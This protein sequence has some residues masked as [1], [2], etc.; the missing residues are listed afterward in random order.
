[1]QDATI[2]MMQQLDF[3]V[4][5]LLL[6]ANTLMFWAIYKQAKYLGTQTKVLQTQTETITKNIQFS[7][8]LRQIE[9]L[10]IINSALIDKE[11]LSKTF[12]KMGFASILE[13][14]SLENKS[15][16]NDSLTMSDFGFSWLV[17][18]RYE[19]AFVANE[20]NLLPDSEWKVWETRIKKD[21][22]HPTIR[23]VWEK[24]MSGFDYNPKFKQYINEF[25]VTNNK[26][27]THLK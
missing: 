5:T 6:V 19:C 14:E 13:K 22:Y 10:N 20:L 12:E 26:Q 1:M 23:Q 18:N 25:M 27:G 8:Y 21:F 3:V 24:D 11:S 7:T 9:Q 16:E 15:M 2:P 4:S 17:I